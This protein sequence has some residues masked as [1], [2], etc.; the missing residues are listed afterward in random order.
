M[1]HD[2]L[3][4]KM[5]LGFLLE[6]GN[7]ASAPAVGGSATVAD[8]L[9]QE[10]VDA[11]LAVLDESDLDM[12]KA[13]FTAKLAEK[14][15]GI[16]GMFEGSD[17]SRVR[18][19]L[20]VIAES[21]N[22]IAIYNLNEKIA[23]GTVRKVFKLKGRRLKLVRQ[24]LAPRA[25]RL[26]RA[27]KNRTRRGFL[28]VKRMKR[29]RKPKYSR[30]ERRRK[31]AEGKSSQ[32][33]AAQESVPDQRMLGGKTEDALDRIRGL[34][35]EADTSVALGEEQENLALAFE[36]L[37]SMFNIALHLADFFEEHGTAGDQALAEA[38]TEMA[39]TIDRVQGGLEE[40]SAVD[41]HLEQ[42]GAL[43]QALGE[44]VAVYERYDIDFTESDDEDEDDDWDDEDEDE[45]ED[46]E[47][48]D[49]DEE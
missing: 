40:S 32:F 18:A 10:C 17:A 23:S 48:D 27:R 5:G 15:K 14:I 35:A 33:K 46:D 49:T 4:K 42:I 39:E 29:E 13:E 21:L 3:M 9:V 41:A 26:K 47:D 28:R 45:D 20:G 22:A 43:A 30:Q 37:E 34:L 7:G 25:E 24:K 16:L 6:S 19:T 1:Q 31:G 2:D 12:P 38:L 44:A 36:S 11:T 8:K